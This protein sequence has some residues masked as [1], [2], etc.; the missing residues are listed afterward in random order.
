M[1]ET[2]VSVQKNVCNAGEVPGELGKYAVLFV[3][4]DKIARFLYEYHDRLCTYLGL[5]AIPLD[6]SQISVHSILRPEQAL[7]MYAIH[8]M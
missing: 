4:P 1:Q 2:S 6:R 8:N 5:P 3:L 7:L